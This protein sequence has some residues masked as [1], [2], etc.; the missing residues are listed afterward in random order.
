MLSIGHCTSFQLSSQKRPPLAH[1]NR[2]PPPPHRLL[3]RFAPSATLGGA[4]AYTLTP[5][6]LP[7]STPF[8]AADGFA[9]AHRRLMR[10]HFV[11][12]GGS[13]LQAWL[14][15]SYPIN[16][17]S[18]RKWSLWPAQAT[19]SLRL[20]HGLCVRG[21]G[22]DTTRWHITSFVWCCAPLDVASWCSHFAPRALLRVRVVP[23]SLRL[24]RHTNE[25]YVQ[26]FAPSLGHH[27]LPRSQTAGLRSAAYRSGARPCAPL[28]APPSRFARVACPRRGRRSAAVH[29]SLAKSTVL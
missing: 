1:R 22:D 23:P 29:S 16:F 5:W 26:S 15:T 6:R 20:T 2:L 27:H 4:R 25:L 3:S 7:R 14:L 28:C 18:S 17:T 13:A 19:P 21:R 9:F 10:P 11:L 8:A 12:S 24:D